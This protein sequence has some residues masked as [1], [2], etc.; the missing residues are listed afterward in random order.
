MMTP[1][2]PQLLQEA[3]A[4]STA[5]RYAD[6]ADIFDVAA[7]ALLERGGVKAARKYRNLAR[8]HRAVVWA[9]QELGDPS[10]HLGQVVPGR[11]QWY[12]PT[13]RWIFVESAP[14]ADETIYMISPRRHIDDPTIV[15]RIDRRGRV[16]RLSWPTRT[17][18]SR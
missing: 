18:R 4:L 6:A 5:R 3:I 2:I 11:R 13:A 16:Q 17:E 10:V 1:D 12:A 7:D 14:N 15:V 9:Q 8:R